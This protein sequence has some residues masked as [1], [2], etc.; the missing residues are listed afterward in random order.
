ML[1][2]TCLVIGSLFVFCLIGKTQ[3]SI[4]PQVPPSGVMQKN[5]LW[6]II[7]V[8]SNPSA[9]IVSV[10]LTLLTVADNNPV[11]TA[12]TKALT[13]S[14]GAKQFSSN[15]LVP[16]QYNYLSPIFNADRN[17]NGFLPVG[18]FQAC[19]SVT[20]IKQGE[21]P[22]TFGLGGANTLAEECIPVEII[23]LSPPILN[24]PFNND[25]ITTNYPSFNW[26]PPAPSSLFNSLSYDLSLVKVQKGQ[27]ILDA[28]QQNVPVYIVSGIKEPSNI[29]PS[30][31]E[32]LDTAV[33]YAWRIIAKNNKQYVAQ[34][35]AF[36][37]SISSVTPFSLKPKD[38]NYLLLTREQGGYSTG[39]VADGVLGIKFY[40]Y[41]RE[42]QT[43]VSI[44]TIRGKE[45]K[46]YREIV[47]Y[48]DNFFVYKLNDTF[49][50]KETYFIELTD[51]EEKQYSATFK[52]K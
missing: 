26:L 40:S 7:L 1:Y 29:Y 48:G 51:K 41:E 46:R 28:L 45:I 31:Y 4:A 13:L 37:F 23:P 30:S 18:N 52:V 25:T 49:S 16:I 21:A 50:N 9:I 19:Y 8:S 27:A 44:K 2:R 5:Q 32:P 3:V 38:N 15:D 6:N 12:T 35:D 43:T 33:Q 22:S 20:Q 24:T 14:Q 47:K 39:F 36:T 17:P 11:M 34:S 42:Y 10:K